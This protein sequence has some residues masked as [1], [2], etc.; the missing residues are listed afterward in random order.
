MLFILSF[1]IPK[2]QVLFFSYLFL[3]STTSICSNDYI[4]SFFYRILT[5]A[6]ILSYP[7]IVFKLTY[8]LQKSISYHYNILLYFLT[9]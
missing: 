3:Y 2:K 1:L 7:L 9:A 6:Y 8:Q 5:T 4:L